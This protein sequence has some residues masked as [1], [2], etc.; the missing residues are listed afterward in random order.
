MQYKKKCMMPD[1]LVPLLRS[2]NLEFKG[3]SEEEAENY[4][5]HI[6]YFRF[7]AYLDILRKEPKK[8]GGFPKDDRFMDGETFDHALALYRFDRKLRMILFNELE[9]IEI[10]IRSAIV[11]IVSYELNDVFW[12]TNPDYFESPPLFKHA[13]S[14]KIIKQKV[15]NSNENFILHFKQRYVDEF[16]PAWMIAEILTFGSLYEIFYGFKVNRIKRKVAR[17]FKINNIDVFQNWTKTLKILRNFCCHHSRLWNRDDTRNIENLTSPMAPWI[18]M[19]PDKQK[20]YFKICI[21]K[22]FL[23]EVSPHN[24]LTKKLE[25]LFE[26]YKGDV[27]PTAMGFPAI[28]MEEPL[29]KREKA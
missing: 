1:Q 7:S 18:T 13:T 10:A 23:N 21:L 25:D 4:I 8:V 16:P 24:S 28:W 15:K 12:L 14:L 22:Y 29:W 6:G 19:I 3:Y 5:G 9:K 17:D 26:K 2:R 20:M 27:D 11:N